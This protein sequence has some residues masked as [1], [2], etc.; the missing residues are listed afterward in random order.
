MT[1]RIRLP[2][3]IFSTSLMILMLLSI[4]GSETVLGEVAQDV[5]RLPEPK[6]SSKTSIEEALRERRSVRDYKDRPLMLSEISQLLW[7]AQG[8]TDP[9]GGQDRTFCRSSLSH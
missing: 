9:G 5:V 8:I 1:N 6:Y 7:A 2:V 3:V 4:R